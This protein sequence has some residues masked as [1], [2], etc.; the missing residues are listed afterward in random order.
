M[1]VL[2]CYENKKEEV[3]DTKQTQ[4]PIP[5][6]ECRENLIMGKMAPIEV[7]EPTEI[8]KQPRNIKGKIKTK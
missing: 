7:T 6:L 4:A 1:G 5:V 2:I 3:K 8:P